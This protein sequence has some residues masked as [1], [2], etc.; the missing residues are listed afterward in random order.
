MFRFSLNERQTLGNL[1]TWHWEICSLKENR[2]QFLPKR[3]VLSC[4]TVKKILTDPWK[5]SRFCRRIYCQV[6]SDLI[7]VKTVIEKIFTNLPPKLRRRGSKSFCDW[8]GWLLRID[9]VRECAVSELVVYMCLD[10]SRSLINR[11]ELE[12]LMILRKFIS[13]AKS[14]QN[15]TYF[16]A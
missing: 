14:W 13:V 10:E 6:V 3:S 9:G 16:L 7:F 4:Q 11:D 5:C 15:F 8:T 12:E 1:F 2:G